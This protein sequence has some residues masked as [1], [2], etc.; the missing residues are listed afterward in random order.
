MKNI[1]IYSSV[2]GNTKKIAKAVSES[3]SCIYISFKDANFVNL[4]EFEF[5]ALGFWVDKGYPDRD[6]KAFMQSIKN[7]NIGL[8]M[9]LG[10]DPKGEHAKKCMQNVKYMMQI[11]GC[12]IKKEFISQGAISPNLINKITK[13]GKSTPHREARWKEAST[14]PDN[15]DL[16][17][18][19]IAFSK[20]KQ[21]PKMNSI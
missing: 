1:V 6:M 12:N 16:L 8:F 14:H 19:K 10:A 2:T 18:A 5:I 11:N 20:N 13:A 9:T 15:N 17:N 4:D 7:K 3:L 21:L